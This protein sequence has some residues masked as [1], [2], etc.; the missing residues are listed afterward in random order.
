MNPYAQNIKQ[1]KEGEKKCSLLIELYCKVSDHSLKNDLW[2]F[3][4]NQMKH[5]EKIYRVNKC[6][7]LIEFQTFG[8]QQIQ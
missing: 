4:N 3:L 5:K 7:I 1:Q 6:M 2:R 8:R